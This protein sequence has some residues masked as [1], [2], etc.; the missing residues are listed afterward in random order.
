MRCFVA[1]EL[2]EEIKK[3]LTRLQQLIKNQGL[4]ASFTKEHHL[5]LKFLGELTPQKVEF[6]K[7][8]LSRCKV[9][10]S[11]IELSDFG[12][13]PGESYIRI[14]WIGLKPEEGIIKL[15]KQVDEAL[16]KDFKKE[17]N[18]RAHITL[19]R[20]KYVNDKE[21]FLDMLKSTAVERLKF[22]VNE[23]KLKR[24]KLTEEG[25]VYE[26]LEVYR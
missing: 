19:A 9:K 25:P 26:D 4:K 18:F 13:F 1:I 24:S 21:K 2:P 7:E 16:Q 8:R 17:K 20:V 23:F 22:E 14:V 3:E 10:K 5:T 12:V 15:Q 6:V 11:V